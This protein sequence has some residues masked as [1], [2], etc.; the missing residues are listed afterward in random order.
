LDY[1]P[2][3]ELPRQVGR[4]AMN[5]SHLEQVTSITLWVV[6][7]LRVGQGRLLTSGMP[8]STQWDL[9]SARL[10]ESSFSPD[11]REWFRA[12][13][14]TS[15]VLRVRRDDAI[16]AIWWPTGGAESPLGAMDVVGRRARR[17]V[18]EDV[19]PGG[20]AGIRGLA[21]EIARACIDLVRWTTN[22]MGP[23]AQLGS[24]STT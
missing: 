8:V 11:M 9:I 15:E 7:E 16:H 2:E 21:N 13:R 3:V 12:W 1:P 22:I 24:G 14:R 19:V 6:A 18:K 23:Q 20:V 10:L 4:V 17:T 5:W